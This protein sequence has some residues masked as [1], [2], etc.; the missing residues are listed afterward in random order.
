[1]A[2]V[3]LPSPS[4]SV[5]YSWMAS[6]N[7]PMA[8]DGKGVIGRKCFQVQRTRGKD[9]AKIV[10]LDAAEEGRELAKDVLEVGHE[11]DR[12]RDGKVTEG[13][14][15]EKV[16]HHARLKLLLQ[17]IKGDR[18]LGNPDGHHQRAR[19]ALPVGLD[20]LDGGRRRC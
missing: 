2:L 7:L 14:D 1:M 8:F 9:P 20:F 6:Q 18:T 15:D 16:R 17:E 19:R 12:V 4:I 13:L 5:T 3:G 10:V 11:K